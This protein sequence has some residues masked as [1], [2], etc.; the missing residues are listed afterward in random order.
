MSYAFSNLPM[1]YKL[2]VLLGAR[3]EVYLKRDDK[4]YPY[5]ELTGIGYNTP[6][7][8][9]SGDEEVF[10]QV[11]EMI[12]QFYEKA[13]YNKYTYLLPKN[14]LKP[15]AITMMEYG[16]GQYV[17]TQ[18]DGSFK[19]LSREEATALLEASGQKAYYST[20]ELVFHGKHEEMDQLEKELGDA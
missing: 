14:A 9:V 16:L 20:F 3:V 10:T 17:Q 13:Q 18:D 12:S 11:Q 8:I 1:I 4:W 5:H 19:E 2:A 6:I 7:R 15:G